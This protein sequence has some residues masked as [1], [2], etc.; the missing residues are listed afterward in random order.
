[1]PT[2][3][4]TETRWAIIHEWKRKPQSDRDIA[5]VFNTSHNAVRKIIN[6]VEAT[7]GVSDLPR[8]GRPRKLK[9]GVVTKMLAHKK[10]SSSRGVARKLRE[11]GRADV[12]YR[13]VSRQAKKEKLKYRVRRKKPLLNEQMKGSR[14]AFAQVAYPPG[15]WKRVV[16]TDEKSIT[17]EGEVRGEWVKEGEEASPRPTH[18]FAPS[19][20]VWAGSSW[21]GK[22]PIYFLPKSL[23]GW[24]YL[25]LI[26][27]KLEPDLLHLYPKKRKPPIW[28]QDREGFH[29]ATVVEK[30]LQES[31]IIPIKDWPSH[32]PDLNWQENVWEMLEQRVRLRCP[33]TIKGLNKV[34]KEEWENVEMASIRNCIRSMEERLEAEVAAQGGSTRY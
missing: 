21:E 34:V 6:R 7:G 22:T 17:L 2:R 26:K 3:L 23:K 32:S 13:T 15:F 1:M 18:K 4:S 31:P 16:A 20:K 14:L 5:R 10:G 24:Q 25:E 12:S 8:R 9:K 33:T 19:V 27:K 30:Y 29:I 11:E 28:L